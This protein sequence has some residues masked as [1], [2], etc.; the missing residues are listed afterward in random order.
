MVLADLIRETLGAGP[1]GAADG[2]A[3]DACEED[4]EQP[5]AVGLVDHR[6]VSRIASLTDLSERS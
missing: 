4:D 5:D 2:V 1:L 3:K 6:D